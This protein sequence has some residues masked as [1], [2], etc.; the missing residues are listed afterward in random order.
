MQ[1]LAAHCHLGL[2]E[3]Y[4]KTGEPEKATVEL[5]AASA[6]FRSMHMTFWLDRAET[7]RA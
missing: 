6:L 1:P 4:T 2:G 3:L 5:T 7:A